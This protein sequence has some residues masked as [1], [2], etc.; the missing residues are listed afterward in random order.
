MARPTLMYA[1]LSPEYLKNL[2]P[3][4]YRLKY[5]MVKI[6]PEQ[7]GYTLEQLLTGDTSGEPA[8][9]EPFTQE[10]MV[11]ALF[12]ENMLSTFLS[13]HRRCCQGKKP[14]MATLTETNASWDV[15]TLVNE[16]SK[17][18]EAIEQGKQSVHSTEETAEENKETEKTEESDSDITEE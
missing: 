16:L 5:R 17:E 13:M 10:V 7:Y 3:I 18:R 1:N 9:A 12:S 8:K 6:D 14:L 4:T 2:M 15:Y 11:F